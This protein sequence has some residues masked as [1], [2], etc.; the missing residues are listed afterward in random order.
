MRKILVAAV[1]VAAF[2]AV[3]CDD[4]PTAVQ[5]GSEGAQYDSHVEQAGNGNAW[6]GYHAPLVVHDQDNS[7]LCATW[8]DAT[9]FEGDFSGADHFSYDFDREVGEEWVTFGKANAKD[10]DDGRTGCMDLS[11]L[12]DGTYRFQVTGM[13]KDGTG[14]ST[15]THHTESWEGEVTIGAGDVF[16]VR[17]TYA[18]GQSTIVN[19]ED[20]FTEAIEDLN[21]NA[22]KWNLKFVVLK[23]FE[24]LEEC[25]VNLDFS[26]VQIESG[27]SEFKSCEDGVYEINL[28]NP[29]QQVDWAGEI[30]VTL[31]E[32]EV[33]NEVNL[34]S[35]AP[36][37][38]R[39]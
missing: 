1:T 26:D 27:S 36:G 15:T 10:S 2:G 29:T 5:L 31:D 18:A 34:S 19:H 30:V 4:A 7:L 24:V 21:H 13:A 3:A 33:E 35:T 14:Q 37:N 22:N 38:G 25:A 39:N 6:H 9:L 28:D 16:H 32:V 17:F 11:E 23:N 8:A 20:G 12:A